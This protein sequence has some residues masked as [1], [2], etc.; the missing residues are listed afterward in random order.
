MWIQ[1]KN[2]A[3]SNL[4]SNEIST[5]EQQIETA[6]EQ[7]ESLKSNISSVELQKKQTENSNNTDESDIKILT[8]KGNVSAEILTYEDK[9]QEYEAYLKDYD[10]KNNNCT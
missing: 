7:I 3:L 10:I 4:E 9:K 2:Q 1:K 5:I 8:E 6:N